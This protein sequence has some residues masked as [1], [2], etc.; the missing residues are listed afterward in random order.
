MSQYRYFIC[1]VDFRTLRLTGSIV[2][3]F[4][5]LFDPLMSDIMFWM[6]IFAMSS[7]G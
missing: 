5:S 3:L 6:A 2:L 1:L 7:I 4:M